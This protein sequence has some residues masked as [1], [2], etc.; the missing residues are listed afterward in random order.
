MMRWFGEQVERRIAGEM[1]AR[2]AKAGIVLTRHARRM[3][4]QQPTKGTGRNRRGLA[5]SAP[6]GYPKRMRPWLAV[7]SNIFYELHPAGMAGRWGTNV[8]YGKW[9]QTGTVRM[10]PR[11][12]MSLTNAQMRVRVNAILSRRIY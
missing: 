4:K 2:I 3:M 8:L 10:K 12:W 9:L 7:G 11:P 6:G 5:P 1:R